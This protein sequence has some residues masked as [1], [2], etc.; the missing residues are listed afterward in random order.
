MMAGVT[1]DLLKMDIEGSEYPLLADSRF[2]RLDV[3]ALVVEWHVTA[4]HPASEG[5]D[6]CLERLHQLGYQT[7]IT[8][9]EVDHGIIWAFRGDP[10]ETAW[11]AGEG[12]SVLGSP[13]G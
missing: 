4:E 9:D 7:Q 5:R 11:H 3:K 10:C 2:E 13:E 12:I 8:C 6:W 1:I